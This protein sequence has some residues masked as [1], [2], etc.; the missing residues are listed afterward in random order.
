MK[1]CER[2]ARLN[3]ER[4]VQRIEAAQGKRRADLCLR[5]GR[6]VNVLSGT[7]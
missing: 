2:S 7:I 6:L 3:S 5:R 4:L 1:G